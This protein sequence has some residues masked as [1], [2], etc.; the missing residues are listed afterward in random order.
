MLRYQHFTAGRYWTS[1]YGDANDS[2]DDFAYLYKYSPLHNVEEGQAYPPILITTADHDDRV[3]PM[4]SKKFAAMLQSA[5]TDNNVILL[6]IDTDAG[7]G[8]GK[9]TAKVIEERADVLAFAATLLGMK[10]EQG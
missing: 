5:N 3:V 4:H 8:A 10:A 9:A 2:A 1:E 6:R 7:H